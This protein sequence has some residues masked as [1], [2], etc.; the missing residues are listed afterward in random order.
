[1]HIYFTLIGSFSIGQ[2]IEEKINNKEPFDT[3]GEQDLFKIPKISYFPPEGAKIN[4]LN[5]ITFVFRLIIGFIYFIK[6]IGY[7]LI[8]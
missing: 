7:L 3:L 2:L 4:K 6:K 5:S 1:M 8:H